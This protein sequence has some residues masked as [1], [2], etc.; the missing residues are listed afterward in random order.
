MGAGRL[1][2]VRGLQ[3]IAAGSGWCWKPMKLPRGVAA[4]D[5]GGGVSSQSRLT[6]SRS[7]LVLS[8]CQ[9]G[10]GP[11][12]RPRHLTCQRGPEPTFCPR[13]PVFYVTHSSSSYPL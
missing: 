10:P 13:Q 11:T 4:T 2:Q 1:A 5:A 7:C 12:S 6:Q 9:S 3:A 8:S